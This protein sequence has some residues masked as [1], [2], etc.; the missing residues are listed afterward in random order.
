VL[1]KCR[2]K[3]TTLQS[4]HKGLKEVDI[5]LEV[6]NI[7]IFSAET[8]RTMR[9]YHRAIDAIAAIDRAIIEILDIIGRG[10]LSDATISWVMAKLNSKNS[11]VVVATPD[12]FG[13]VVGRKF[14]MNTDAVEVT[15]TTI[16][17][18]CVLV[19]IS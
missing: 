1:R 7:G 2:K 19:P 12:V 9:N 18:E 14:T 16:A 3:V 17:G 13:W 15:L 4:K 6:P 5:V 8:L 10:N 11:R